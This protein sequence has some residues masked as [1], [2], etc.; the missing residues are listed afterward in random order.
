[1]AAYASILISAGFDKFLEIIDASPRQAKEAYFKR[2]SIRAKSTGSRFLKPGEK[3]A[4]RTEKL[5]DALKTMDDDELSE[6]ILQ[7]LED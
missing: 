2:H 7:H 1:M 5:F 6:E 4:Q 3:M